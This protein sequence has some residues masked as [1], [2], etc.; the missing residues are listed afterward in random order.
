M[1]KIVFFTG[2]LSHRG[3][4][5]RYSKNLIEQLNES[6]EVV[7]LTAVDAQNE[8]LPGVVIYKILPHSLSGTGMILSLIKNYRRVK[9]ITKGADCFHALIEPYAI[10]AWALSAGKP[11]FIT[12]HGTYAIWALTNKYFSGLNKMI[13]S[14]ARQI[15]CVS[16]F[17][18]RAIEEKAALK[19]LVV[20]NNG[21]DFSRFADVPDK[22][23]AHKIILGVG[24]IKFRKGY[25]LVLDSLPE[26]KKH[27][28]DIKYYM[29][30]SD[31]DKAYINSLQA[32]I[33]QN[34]LEENVELLKNISDAKMLDLYS[35]CSVFAL[36]PV[37]ADG[38]FEG[39]GIAYLEA[40]ACGKPVV[41]SFGCGAEDAVRN[42]ETGFLVP[43]NDSKAIAEAILRLFK[44]E[45]LARKMGQAG[46]E[47]AR[48]RDWSNVA[49]EYKIYYI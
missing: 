19:N 17:T 11:Y 5:A 42:G 24:D 6:F 35:K 21:I 7:V 36:T 46:R 49:E 26:I 9:K 30:G 23:T 16:S 31:G 28:P 48:G 38:Q 4:W 10:W 1:K 45:T 8:A 25:H 20:I 2:E 12:S 43:Q 18:K 13:F 27:F 34:G 44:D 40:G 39:F 47:Y 37:N 33:K 14:G 32:T 41:G 22:Q 15:F 29:A 3:G